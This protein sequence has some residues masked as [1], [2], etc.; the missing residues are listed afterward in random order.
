MIK[1]SEETLELYRESLKAILEIHEE[2]IKSKDD[3]IYLLQEENISLKN[4]LISIQEVYEEERALV[5]TLKEQIEHLQK[6][7]D[8]AKRK[9]KLMWNQAIENY[10]NKPKK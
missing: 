8:F 5:K 9:Y 3:V 1:D 4:S 2:M 7:L 6:E 10:N